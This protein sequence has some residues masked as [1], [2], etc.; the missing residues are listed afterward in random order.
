MMMRNDFVCGAVS[1]CMEA[2]GVSMMIV[3]WMA[4]L[5]IVL[6]R[7]SKAADYWHHSKHN[8]STAGTHHSTACFCCTPVTQAS[9]LGS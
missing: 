9:T 3:K 7:D 8:T 6:L 5:N 2:E 4:G 1:C